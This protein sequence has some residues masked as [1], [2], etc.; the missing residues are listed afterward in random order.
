MKIEITRTS[1]EVLLPVV[2]WVQV[3]IGQLLRKIGGKSTY[4]VLHKGR[5]AGASE[6]LITI[7]LLRINPTNEHDFSTSCLSKAA[8]DGGRFYADHESLINAVTLHV[9]ESS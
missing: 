7:T 5:P 6:D 2:T 8:F 9:G 1:P 4:I 3:R